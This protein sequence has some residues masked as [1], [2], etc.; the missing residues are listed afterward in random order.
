MRPIIFAAGLG[1]LSAGVHAKVTIDGRA[2]EADW[3]NARR[4]GDFVQIQPLSETPIP[5]RYATEAMLLSTPEG[6]AVNIRA[7][8]PKDVPRTKS[9]IPRDADGQM[10]RM[11]FMVDFDGEGR[12]G[13][14]FT[15][16]AGGDIVDSVISNENQFTTDWDGDW[17]Y[18]VHEDDEGAS[19][20][21]K[22]NAVEGIA[23]D[24]QRCSIA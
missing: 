13:F 6:I 16:T 5:E 10:D 24:F 3:A 9:R 21:S 17:Q 23:E 15:V 1:L 22:C 19:S 18:A 4:F 14:D 2:D 11:N 8:Q 12:S 20:T 7:K